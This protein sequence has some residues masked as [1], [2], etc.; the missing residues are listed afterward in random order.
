M[1]H[2]YIATPESLVPLPA[3]RDLADADWI[4]LYHPLDAQIAEVEALGITL[5][6]L[7]DMEEIEISNRLYREDGAE[8]MIT[9]LPGQMPDGR[10]TSMPVAFVLTP[11]RLI[12]LRYHASRPFD[13]FP[14]RAERSSAGIGSSDRLFLGLIEEII[15]RMADLLEGVGRELDSTVTT[16]LNQDNHG[17]DAFHREALRLMGVQSEIMAR[18]RLGL[19][20]IERVLFFY[21]T[22]TS[23]HPHPERLRV[24]AKG[25]N[26][27]VQ[28]LEVHADFLG[29]RVSL[30][31]DTTMG[32]INVRQNET[33]RI[34]SVVA[35]LFLPPTLI[36]SIYGMNFAVMPELDYT[37]AYPLSILAMLA[38]AVG[39]YLF[40]KW[41]GWL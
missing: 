28:A 5:P 34:L 14:M 23:E 9:V 7:E 10:Q 22:V 24:L 13:T 8:F 15:S 11:K 16:V 25:L 21:N 19:L 39:T 12:T 1:L 36:A 30:T 37:W 41:K 27:D 38:S 29:S 20:T 18:V 40:I 3:G 26:R 35:A 2:A 17:N 4:D 32:M 33:V 31:I 6:T